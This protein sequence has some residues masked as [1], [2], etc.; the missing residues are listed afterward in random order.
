[1]LILYETSSALF[2]D[3]ICS[4]EEEAFDDDL[5]A[6]LVSPRTLKEVSLGCGEDCSWGEEAFDEDLDAGLVSPITLKEA[7]LV[8]TGED[9]SWGEEAF[10][11]D[12]EAGLLV[13]PS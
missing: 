3:K 11:E 6:D 10:D 7:S 5:D 1:M 9:C 2:G 12:F 13:L 4:W 8:C